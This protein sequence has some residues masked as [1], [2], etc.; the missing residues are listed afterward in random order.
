MGRHRE[1]LIGFDL[2]TT[3]TDPRTTRVV[4]PVVAAN[5][6]LCPRASAGARARRGAAGSGVLR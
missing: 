4:P 6:A 5:A 2:E 3:G 1:P